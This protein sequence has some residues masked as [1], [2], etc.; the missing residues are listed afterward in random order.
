[1]FLGVKPMSIQ[2]FRVASLVMCCGCFHRTDTS[3]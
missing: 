3:L 1:M 2:K